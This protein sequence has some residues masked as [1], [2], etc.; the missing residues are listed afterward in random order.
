MMVVDGNIAIS[1]GSY[2][3]P[4]APVGTVCRVPVVGEGGWVVEE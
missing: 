2:L 3:D 1:V 4:S